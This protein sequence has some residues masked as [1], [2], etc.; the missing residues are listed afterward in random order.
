MASRSSAAGIAW[1]PRYVLVIAAAVVMS[2]GCGGPSSSPT[3]PTPPPRSLPVVQ[4]SFDPS[5]VRATVVRVV[6]GTVTYRVDATVRFTETAGTAGQITQVRGT[7]VRTPGGNV[8]GTLTVI[9]QLPARGSVSGAYSQEFDISEPADVLW[10][11]SASGVDD[12][13]RVFESQVGQ[14]NVLPP[15]SETIPTG[16]SRLEIWGGPG[17]VQFLGCLTCNEFARESVFNQ[18]GPYGSRFSSTSIWNHFSQYGSQFSTNSACNEFATNPP[19][20][21]NVSANT[22]V[23]LTL[24]TFR[25]FA[26]RDPTVLNWLQRTVCER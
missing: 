24:N 16:P 13:G 1:P 10:Q 12:M 15:Q 17:Y 23:E 21:I 11:F 14:V 6:Q 7:I 26:W 25:P 18:F 8:S 5:P 2:G 22:F 19:R 3:A 4:L 9:L 20:V